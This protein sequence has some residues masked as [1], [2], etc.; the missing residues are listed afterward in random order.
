MIWAAWTLFGLLLFGAVHGLFCSEDGYEVSPE[1]HFWG[2]IGGAV[3]AAIVFVF[4][5]PSL[6]VVAWALFGLL[7]V[8]AFHGLTHLEETCEYSPESCCVEMVIYSALAAVVF[9][10]FLP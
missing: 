7:V 10:F 5:L 9:V 1:D 8:G 2:M 6:S 3:G 4:L